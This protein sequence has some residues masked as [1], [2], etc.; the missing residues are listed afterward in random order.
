MGCYRQNLHTLA[1]TQWENL[2]E[3]F[4]PFFFVELWAPTYNSFRSMWS[5]KH[6]KKRI[7]RWRLTW[8]FRVFF[9]D[10]KVICFVRAHGYCPGYDSSVWK[11]GLDKGNLVEP[12]YTVIVEF[13]SHIKQQTTSRQYATFQR[14]FR[15]FSYVSYN[16]SIPAAPSSVSTAPPWKVHLSK[17]QFALK[18]NGPLDTVLGKVES[19]WNFLC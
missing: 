18:Q 4:T 15:W 6:F 3:N 13:Y 19:G 11:F 2:G 1:E 8:F 7:C 12:F 14:L 16:K 17:G 10:G 9:R 5:Q